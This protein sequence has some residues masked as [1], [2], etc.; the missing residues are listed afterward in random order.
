MGG[1]Q[2]KLV[3]TSLN[4]AWEMEDRNPVC[5]VVLIDVPEHKRAEE[6]SVRQAAQINSLLASD[7]NIVFFKNVDGTRPSN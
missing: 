7:P 1:A 5:R 2:R 6:E 3:S 4:T